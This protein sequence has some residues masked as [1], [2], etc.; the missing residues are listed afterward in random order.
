MYSE[1]DSF[2]C[3]KQKIMQSNVV[4]FGRNRRICTI[5]WYR[6]NVGRLLDR[7]RQ[8]DLSM[9]A[10]MYIALSI[11]NNHADLHNSAWSASAGCE[12]LVDIIDRLLREPLEPAIVQWRSAIYW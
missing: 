5:S 8:R 11:G 10:R 3:F 4:Q 1:L 9:V 6:F 12:V 7:S 2:I